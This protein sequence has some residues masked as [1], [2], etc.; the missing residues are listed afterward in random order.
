MRHLDFYLL[1]GRKSLITNVKKVSGFNDVRL[2]FSINYSLTQRHM[3]EKQNILLCPS[4]NIKSLDEFY[5]CRGLEMRS[6]TPEKELYPN[7]LG[8]IVCLITAV[9]RGR[10]L[11]YFIKFWNKI[12]Y[13]L[14]TWWGQ[15]RV[16][17]CSSSLKKK[18]F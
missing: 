11:L 10:V 15:E 17:T 7:C 16:E 2:K 8:Y 18:I 9:D 12:M 14:W 1:K 13:I 3:P 5:V 4:E 6:T